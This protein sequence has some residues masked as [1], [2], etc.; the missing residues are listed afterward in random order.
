MVQT[1]EDLPEAI[2]RL[3]DIARS[4]FPKFAEVALRIRT[5]EATLIPLKFN[6]PRS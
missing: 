1:E 6:R 5:K 3:H 2:N 4:D